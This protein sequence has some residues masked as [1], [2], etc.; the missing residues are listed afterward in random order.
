MS[1]TIFD[2]AKKAK[3]SKSTVSRV[4]NNA[5]GVSPDAVAA[6][7]QAV[8]ELGFSP[9]L[10]KGPG[11]PKKSRTMK[12]GNIAFMVP[13]P[14]ESSL[15]TPLSS[16]LL[17]GIERIANANELNLLLTHLYEDDMPVCV[18]R[19]QI[20]GLLIRSGNNLAE[21]EN[22][23]GN[24]PFVIIFEN[25]DFITQPNQ[26]NPDNQAIG[27]LA[28][29]YLKEQKCKKMAVI[30]RL[31]FETHSASVNRCREFTLQGEIN[32]IPV[33]GNQGKQELEEFIKQLIKEKVDG[34]FLPLGDDLIEEVYR[35]L[36][37]LGKKPIEGI[38]IISCNND[39]NRL[40]ALD[41][42]LPNIDLCAEQ[43]G[44]TAAELL[45]SII[46][47]PDSEPK[48]ILIQPKLVEK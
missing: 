20:D 36:V 7:Q 21:I 9:A 14:V 22:K 48:R 47:E 41:P 33:L 26:V 44:K 4:L 34:I 5:Y 12:T 23:L 32:G 6:V 37:K 28:F 24:I 8:K 2:V 19:K 1:L 18:R 42:G 29:S 40:R 30:T 27:R 10:S 46:A 11:R 31:N 15:H 13:D 3:V 17:N 43:I 16:R 38:K 45:L 25:Q 35:T 39:L